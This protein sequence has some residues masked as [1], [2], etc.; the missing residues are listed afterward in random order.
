MDNIKVTE[1]RAGDRWVVTAPLSGSFGAAEVTVVNVGEQGVQLTHAQPLRIATRARLSIRGAQI[2]GMVI[3]S[4]LSKTPN[5]EGKYLY[6]SG[7]RLEPVD[8]A[9]G[10]V[11]Q[12]LRGRNQLLRD[13][14]SLDRKRQRVAERERAPRPTMKFLRTESEIP[15]DQLLLVQHARERLRTNPDEAR[16][17]YQRARFAIDADDSPI[18]AE[19]RHREDVLAVWE[20]LERTVP[21]AT[22]VRVFEKKS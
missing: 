20:Y 8:D 14:T 7:V 6:Q 3:W 22:I 9:F 13:V 16:K 10:A 18:A 19:I 17:W 4:R 1:L 2:F 11:L 12:S 21:L 5:D 15:S